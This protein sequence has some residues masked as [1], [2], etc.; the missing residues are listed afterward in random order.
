MHKNYFTRHKEEKLLTLLIISLNIKRYLGYFCDKDEKH[1]YS[2]RLLS[3]PLLNGIIKVIIHAR[4]YVLL[5]VS[6][7]RNEIF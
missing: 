4:Y 5:R 3:L 2:W 6:S 7:K 1:K